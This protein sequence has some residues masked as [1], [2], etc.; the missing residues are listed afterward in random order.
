MTNPTAGTLMPGAQTVFA[1]RISESGDYMLQLV[2]NLL[3]LGRLTRDD[4]EGLPTTMIDAGDL[5]RQI[6]DAH[7]PQAAE[8]AQTLAFDQPLAPV[9]IRFNDLALRQILTNLL[10]N[11]IK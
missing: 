1:K 8:K 7:R 2:N 10:A 9:E 3:D 11:A 6:V 4:I 5:T